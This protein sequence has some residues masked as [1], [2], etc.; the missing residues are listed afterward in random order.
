MGQLTHNSSY[1]NNLRIF[2]Y[3]CFRCEEPPGRTT[4]PTAPGPRHRGPHDLHEH[5][6]PTE[7]EQI[8]RNVGPTD[9]TVADMCSGEGS[10]EPAAHVR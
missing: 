4:S 9:G 7:G 6:L 1:D 2:F 5:A 3:V 10:V 8:L